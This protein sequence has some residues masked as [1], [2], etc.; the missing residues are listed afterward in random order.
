MKIKDPKQLWKTTLAQIEVKLDAPAQ[1]KTFFK[2]TDISEIKGRKVIIQVPNP[3]TADW[4]KMRYKSLI[5]ETVSYV[6]GET[7]LPE[8]EVSGGE[9]TNPETNISEEINPLF[10][11]EDGVMSSVIK[12][13]EESGLNTKYSFSNFV[14]GNANRL[15]HAAALA[16]VDKPGQIYNPLFIYG[17][18]G[19][20]KT[21]IAQ[22]I[23][24]AMLE[25][26]IS[27]KIVYITS[28]NFLNEMVR[29]LRSGKMDAFRKKYRQK[30]LLIIDDMQLIS[31][32]VHTKDEFFNTFNELYNAG[33]QIVI[34]AD[35]RPEDIKDLESRLRSRMLGGMVVDIKQPD[36]E[37]RLAIV[38]KKAESMGI[39][40]KNKIL[41]FIARA[42]SDNVR[43][44]EGALQKVSLF[45]Q[46]KPG[47][48]LSLEEVAHMLGKDAKSKRE[49]VK[50]P[51]VLR[52]VAK[53]F[54]VKVKDLK[55]P[56]RTKDIAMARQVAMF[57]LR[58]EFNHKLEDVAGFLNRS[59]HTTVLH[60]IDKVKSKMMLQEDFNYQISQIITNINDSAVITEDID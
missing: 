24:R 60:A 25:R 13:I 11:V 48:D 50:V 30:D 31:K 21:H 27:R 41:E 14:I 5:Q 44:L 3:Y 52:E 33:K 51:K 26:N 28:E 40:L 57:I 34:I 10:A 53:S 38:Q 4:L 59:D 54:N 46:M 15:A 39:E 43:E 45:N 18:T 49:Q 22:A 6:Y 9:I 19:V 47:G 12:A 36:Y 20:G 55:G 29:G 58:E 35:R 17:K 37:M 1:F 56:R 8:F 42:I 23:G 2:D 16:V 7:L 32:W